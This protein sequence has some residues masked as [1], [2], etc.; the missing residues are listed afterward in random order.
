[1][2][3]RADDMLISGGFNAWPVELENV[4]AGHPAVLEVAVFGIPYKRWGE[5]P[6]ALC[7]VHEGMPMGAREL[8]EWVSKGLGSYK[9]PVSVTYTNEALPKSPVGKIKCKDLRE[10][11]WFGIDRRVSGS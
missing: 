9:K 6:H 5:T 10:P 4:L 7:T 11:F 1:M 2:A 3:D 8:I